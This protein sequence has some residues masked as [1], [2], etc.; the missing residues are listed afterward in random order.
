MNRERSSA[1]RQARGAQIRAIN[2]DDA[3]QISS[4]DRVVDYVI[5]GILNGRFVPGQRLVEADLARALHVSRG[6]VREAFRR[7]DALGAITGTMHR[8]ACVRALTRTEL[9]DFLAAIEPI[10]G[11]IAYI[12][13]ERV[14]RLKR[15]GEIAAIEKMLQPYRDG[16]EDPGD[17][18]GQRRQ[19]YD[20]LMEIGG[21]SQVSSLQPTVRIHLVRLQIQSY[22]GPEDRTRHLEDYAR[23]AKA[24]L[25]GKP[26]EAEKAIRLHLRTICEAAAGLPDAAFPPVTGGP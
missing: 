14:G 1:V 15:A 13:A 5:S 3:Q 18:L 23:V 25:A 10:A 4:S 26:G 22:L 20:S 17:L 8:G 7:L 6:P 11:F 21:N 9:I 12:A 24:V 19:F 16:V 2:A